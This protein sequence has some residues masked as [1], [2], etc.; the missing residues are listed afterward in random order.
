MPIAGVAIDV[1]AKGV[2]T[3]ETHVPVVYDRDSN[4]FGG[5]L[6]MDGPQIGTLKYSEPGDC[7]RM[8]INLQYAQPNT[9]YE[10]F[11]VAGPS[12]N[13]AAGYRI[14][15]TLTTKADGTDTGTLVVSHATLQNAPFGP[16]YRTDHIDMLC[17]VGNLSHGCLTA[18]GINYFI[19]GEKP[20]PLPVELKM[21]ET[22]KGTP[23]TGDPLHGK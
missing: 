23:G 8:E 20:H 19:S 18:G 11:L 16:G 1:V 2:A 21:V 5:P 17:D 13:V 12:H 15:G 4:G 22:L 3:T 9:K 6:D 14:I 7:L 10:V